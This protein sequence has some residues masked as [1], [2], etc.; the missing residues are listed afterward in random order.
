M[1]DLVGDG[2]IDPLNS[3][4]NSQRVESNIAYFDSKAS[5]GQKPTDRDKP[6]GFL[7]FFR[8]ADALS[9]GRVL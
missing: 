3:L 9:L 7:G 1:G 5:F 4:G 8:F 6:K 2:R